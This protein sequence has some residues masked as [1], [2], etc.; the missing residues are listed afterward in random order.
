MVRTVLLFNRYSSRNHQL[1]HPHRV[2]GL[3]AQSL[4][5]LSALL[6]LLVPCLLQRPVQG[7]CFD[8]GSSLFVELPLHKEQILLQVHS[9]VAMNLSEGRGRHESVGCKPF[10]FPHDKNDSNLLCS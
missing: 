10:T 7:I 6:S 4:H 1:I 5:H 8:A 2:L 9:T 3:Y